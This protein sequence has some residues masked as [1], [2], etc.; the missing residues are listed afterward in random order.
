MQLGE[1]LPL[2]NFK[3]KKCCLYKTL[4]V[5]ASVRVLGDVIAKAMPYDWTPSDAPTRTRIFSWFTSDKFLKRL[6]LSYGVVDANVGQNVTPHNPS[7]GLF[8]YHFLRMMSSWSHET[9]HNNT[10]YQQTPPPW[11]WSRLPL[12]WH[13]LMIPCRPRGRRPCACLFQGRCQRILFDSLN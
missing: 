8:L 6:V 7:L 2:W 5:A 13:D 12:K 3:D 9:F 4:Y 11:W 1:T 10:N